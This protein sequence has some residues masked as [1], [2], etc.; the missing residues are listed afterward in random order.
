MVAI[1]QWGNDWVYGAGK[2][3]VRFVSRE[4]GATIT[5]LDPQD[6][7]GHPVNWGDVDMMLGPGANKAMR[8][9]F[10]EQKTMNRK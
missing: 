10:A 3:P 5:S 2:E 4:T 9:R 1:S 6:K 7:D 8:A